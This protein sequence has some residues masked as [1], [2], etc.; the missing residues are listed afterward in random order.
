MTTII[1]KL[2][3]IKLL[4]V[5][6]TGIP[7]NAGAAVTGTFMKSVK[8]IKP[9][10]KK[11]TPEQVEDVKEIAKIMK[12]TIE[13][14]P[15]AGYADF[16]DCV[17]KNSDK[18]DPKAYCATIMR[19]VEGKG[20]RMEKKTYPKDGLHV[21]TEELPQGEHTHPEIENALADM[22]RSLWDMSDRISKRITEVETPQAMSRHEGAEKKAGGIMMPEE[23]KKPE[24]EAKADPAQ[25]EVKDAPKD[26]SNDIAE[27]KTAVE[28]A[29][30]DAS[31]KAAKII[32]L[33][34][35]IK[36]LQKLV[37]TPQLKARLE[38][39]THDVEETKDKDGK[40]LIQMV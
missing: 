36:E 1:R 30:T 22:Q 25:P 20:D 37:A 19:N 24:T 11:P 26:F 3:K 31:E 10:G 29:K 33:E 2:K 27:L 14:K 40:T 35:E 7:M 16:A 23:K 34:A 38:H 39:V 28:T 9:E 8:E 13:G 5:A 4:N 21:H 18:D 32:S 6:L 17:A 12:D 15:F